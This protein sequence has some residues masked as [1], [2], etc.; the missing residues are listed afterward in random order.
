MT[1]SR[2]RG[3]V[4]A[5]ALA[6]LYLAAASPVAHAGN[7]YVVNHMS[8]SVSAIDTRTDQVVA[9]IPVGDGPYG[10]AVSP[11]GR[12][13]Y[14]A[15][16]DSNTVSV[17]DIQTNGV[18]ATIPV[19]KEPTAVAFT[20]DGSR[21]YVTN[22]GATT[23]SVVDTQT[24]QVIGAPI[25]VGSEPVALAITPDGKRVLVLR[26]GPSTIEVIDTQTDQVS[27]TAIPVG[28]LPSAITITADGSKAYVTDRGDEDVSVV[29][30]ATDK[31][32]PQ[33]IKVGKGPLAIAIS[34]DGKTAYVANY[35]GKSVSVINTQAEKATGSPIS[36]GE[37][38]IGI[39]LSANGAK[40][41]VVDSESKQVSVIDTHTDQLTG[42]PIGV[43]TQPFGM[44]IA[45][46]ETPTASFSVGRARP[47]V[48]VTL[49]ASGS[50][51]A[52]S[53]ITSFSWSF[54]DGQAGSGSQVSHVFARPGRSDVTLTTDNGEGCR[55]FLFTGQTAFCGGPST[56]SVAQVVS[57]AYPGVRL[58]C[59]KHA[60]GG[61]RFQVQAIK[62]R[63]K[64]GQRA[65]SESAL[66]RIKVKAGSSAIV[67]LKPK[68]AFNSRLAGASRILV[69]E[70]STISGVTDKRVRLLKVVS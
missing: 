40:A 11:D 21:A 1:P 69:V 26:Y 61:C 3:L 28:E 36:A 23:V 10:V 22:Y 44:A 32:L 59:P 13:A 37:Y 60:K 51:D 18:V 58:S 48:P 24:N 14:V 70:T 16:H 4:P 57:V 8:S 42:T 45:P 7:G 47:G 56:A 25:T 53:A 65:K 55:G 52:G 66:A 31:A 43:G 20:P 5:L 46:A 19:G 50:S 27:G 2:R 12:R 67:P 34:P 39:S 38:P 6:A 62:K 9:T 17:I 63:P 35:E 54:G 29:D 15:N 49:D 30:L 33:T 68:K 41:Y 64:R